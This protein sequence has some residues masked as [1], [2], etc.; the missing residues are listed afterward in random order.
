MEDRK[1]VV[2]V[3]INGEAKAYPIEILMWHEI[4]NDTIACAGDGD[5]LPAL[6]Y[7]YC[8]RPAS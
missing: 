3:K 8:L 2:A 1:P 6:Q 4:V 5:F 7:R